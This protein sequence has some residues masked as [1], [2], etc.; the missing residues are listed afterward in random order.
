MY[1]LY[2][3]FGDVLWSNPRTPVRGFAGGLRLL[4]NALNM[5]YFKKCITYFFSNR[6]FFNKIVIYPKQK[7]IDI[8]KKFSN[9]GFFEFSTDK[10]ALPYRGYRAYIF[11]ALMR[12]L[13]K[14]MLY[15]LPMVTQN[16]QNQRGVRGGAGR[17]RLY[18][19]PR[20]PSFFKKFI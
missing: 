14:C 12:P 3:L 20:P 9:Q 6:K 19:H 1:A 11:L 7:C 4:Q 10:N 15:I 17:S 16:K 5:H 8:K 18:G 13:K 2:P